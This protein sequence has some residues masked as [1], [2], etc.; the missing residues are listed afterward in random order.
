MLFLSPFF[1]AVS[2]IWNWRVN[3]FRKTYVFLHWVS[4][5][6]PSK[7]V[8]DFLPHPPAFGKSGEGEVVRVHFAESCKKH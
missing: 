1:R 3:F 2:S 7:D 5:E 8:K 4:P 6:L